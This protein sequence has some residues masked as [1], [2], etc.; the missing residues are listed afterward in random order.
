ML[1][2][3]PTLDPAPAY[4]YPIRGIPS[5]R[6]P[7]RKRNYMPWNQDGIYRK[8]FNGARMGACYGLGWRWP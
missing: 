4:V 1:W 2:F 3:K 6:L 7:G 5:T 8:R